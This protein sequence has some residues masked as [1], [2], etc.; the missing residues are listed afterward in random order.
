MGQRGHKKDRMKK[1]GQKYRS[2][3]TENNETESAVSA[4]PSNSK[5]WYN[6]ND[7][8]KTLSQIRGFGGYVFDNL[9]PGEV[10]ANLIGFIPAMA[11]LV[12][13][14]KLPALKQ[15]LNTTNG[16]LNTTIAPPLP[17]ST[18]TPYGYA[19]LINDRGVS[20]FRPNLLSAQHKAKN[21]RER[22]D[23]RESSSNRKGAGTMRRI[24]SVDDVDEVEQ[25]VEEDLYNLDKEKEAESLQ[26]VKRSCI[27]NMIETL[28]MRV[29]NFR[30]AYDLLDE[31]R[32]KTEMSPDMP[33]DTPPDMPPCPTEEGKIIEYNAIIMSD[34]V[35]RFVYGRT[36]YTGIYDIKKI[37]RPVAAVIR[38]GFEKK[39]LPIDQNVEPAARTLANV[40][41][42]CNLPGAACPN[43]QTGDLTFPTGL[44]FQHGKLRIDLNGVY[45]QVKYAKG[46]V[47]AKLETW[48]PIHYSTTEKRWLKGPAVNVPSSEDDSSQTVFADGDE[49]WRKPL[50]RC[51]GN[52]RLTRDGLLEERGICAVYAIS[53]QT[54]AS[55]KKYGLLNDQ[56][57]GRV[58]PMI[59]HRKSSVF[60]AYETIDGALKRLKELGDGYKLYKVHV[61]W[62]PGVSLLRN[63]YD[64]PEKLAN[65][66]HVP[67]KKDMDWSTLTH[68]AIDYSEVHFR[69]HDVVRAKRIPV[70]LDENSQVEKQKDSS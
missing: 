41:I 7:Y 53:N 10:V 1:T 68:G 65:F 43:F 25:P 58:P 47:W 40:I 11:A 44:S 66:L 49:T 19:G 12:A 3:I 56:K 62:R 22:R 6:D 36:N 55:L 69:L 28:A 26:R 24:L 14:M 21:K 60:I 5:R 54:D 35:M 4:S 42:Y 31:Y 37:W 33:P 64:N 48:T 45:R 9:N 32:E 16:T 20:S 51:R 52:T 17:N 46:K 67:F 27:S 38:E 63:V 30:M 23:V 59:E 57:L 34:E 8:D 39:H 61:H 18:V 50:V 70:I 2:P 13:Q 15:T 29:P